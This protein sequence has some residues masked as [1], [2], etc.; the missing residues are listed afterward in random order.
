MEGREEKLTIFGPLKTVPSLVKSEV[1]FKTVHFLFKNGSF[2]DLKTVPSLSKKVCRHKDKV[3]G[4]E[5]ETGGRS[6]VAAEPAQPS[7]LITTQN[8]FCTLRLTYH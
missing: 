3:R 7:I 4:G 2:L 6:A 1:S 8:R 5:K